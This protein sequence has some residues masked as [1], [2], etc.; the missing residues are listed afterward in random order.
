ME[1]RRAY[2]TQVGS[3]IQGLLE[4]GVKVLTCWV[5]DKL[6]S[7]KADYDSFAIWI[8]PNQESPDGF[9]KILEG[10]GWYYYFEQVNLIGKEKVLLKI[11]SV[12]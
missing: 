5:N 3:A 8:F 11:L 4:Q 10:T 7:K 9:Q 2:M 1:E 6:I 12:N